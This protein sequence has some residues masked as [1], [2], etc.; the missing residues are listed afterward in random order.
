MSDIE[1]SIDDLSKEN[2]A[3]FKNL[4]AIRDYAKETRAEVNEF[5]KEIVN[6]QTQLNQLRL[7]KEQMQQQILQ[8]LQRLV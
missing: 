7:E 3:G 8:I 4:L 6:L 1:T 2:S 5:R